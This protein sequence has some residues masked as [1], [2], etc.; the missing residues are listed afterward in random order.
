MTNPCILPKISVLINKQNKWLI[1]FDK[2]NTG[3]YS[4]STKLKMIIFLW[5]LKFFNNS[6]LFQCM[7]YFYYQ[8]GYSL[9]ENF[10]NV[11]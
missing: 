5:R 8:C 6:V 7:Q 9:K 11:P 10:P 4:S 1:F 2:E 3:N